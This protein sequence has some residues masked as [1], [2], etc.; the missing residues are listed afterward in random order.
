MPTIK[1]RYGWKKKWEVFFLPTLKFNDWS[2][3]HQKQ[4]DDGSYTPVKDV[5]E[6]A[7]TA[8]F[9]TCYFTIAYVKETPV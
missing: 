5:V 3:Q 9:L 6:Y 7:F 1:I 4:E 8:A 2:A